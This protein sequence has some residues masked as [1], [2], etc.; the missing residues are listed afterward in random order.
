MGIVSG[1]NP[2]ISEA[3]LKTSHN[4][5]P[6]HNPL[7]IC[8]VMFTGLN[9]QLDITNLFWVTVSVRVKGVRVKGLD[10]G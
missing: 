7:A 8:N 9:K 4:K 1:P 6:G 10:Q 2:Q 5:I 3:Q